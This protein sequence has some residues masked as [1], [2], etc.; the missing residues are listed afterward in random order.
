VVAIELT[1]LPT[2][3]VRVDMDGSIYIYIQS[4]TII[5]YD[6]ADPITGF[7]DTAKCKRCNEEAIMLSSRLCPADFSMVV[8]CPGAVFFVGWEAVL[9]ACDS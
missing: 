4:N 1:G 3:R 2:L 8:E 9:K 5:Q 7:V 6:Y